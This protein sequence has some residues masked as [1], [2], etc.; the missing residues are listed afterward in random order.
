MKNVS[1]GP[2]ERTY[3]RWRIL[4]LLALAIVPFLNGISNDFTYDDKLIIRDNSRLENRAS[5]GLVFTTHYF[6]GSLATGQNYRPVVL[7]SYAVQR[8][9]HGN[10]APLFRVVNIA[11]HA[12]VCILLFLWIR[13]LGFGEGMSFATSLWFAAAAI[14]VE[15]VT[16]LVGRAEL[17]AALLVLSSALFWLWATREPGVAFGPY[18]LALVCFLISVFVKE[19]AVVL[20]GVILLGELFR[21]GRSSL[22]F[23]RV[24]SEMRPRA[25]WIA[26]FAFPL[27][28]LFGVRFFVLQGFL[29]SRHAG[30]FEVE[31]PLVTVPA[32]LRGMNGVWLLGRYA[33]TA[34]FP[35][36]LAADHSAYALRPLTWQDPGLLVVTAIG[37]LALA[38]SV[39][40]LR[41]TT[42]AFAFGLVFFA[43][44][45]FPASNIP[46]AVG[47]IFAERLAY[48]PSAG[49]F[50]AVLALFAPKEWAV[51]RHSSLRWRELLLG[52]VVLVNVVITVERNRVW[53]DDTALF[54]DM[55]KK[56]PE[57]SKARYNLA[58][59]L[60][61][62]KEYREARK[63]LAKA[64]EIFPR[65]YDAH[66]LLGRIELDAGNVEKSVASYRR[67]A[68]IF[69][70]NERVL[71]GL[72]S[73]LEASARIGEAEEMLR[74]SI[75]VLPESEGLSS[76][77]ARLLEKKGEWRRAFHE[78]RRAR[79]LGKGSAASRA[80]LARALER[81]GKSAE[82]MDEARWAAWKDPSLAEP[83]FVMAEIYEEEGKFLPACVE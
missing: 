62:R 29:L 18:S 6:G 26:G 83:R 15:A 63:H 73:A 39:L 10:R 32:F 67:A 25:W 1:A 38:C 4:C 60:F 57:S 23:S 79:I 69:P 74:A 47:T 14:H 9:V 52:A 54:T 8:W 72:S 19:S 11:M 31:N 40:V 51:P 34:L 76:A 28:V 68:A 77:R 50:L 36:D 24:I 22:S 5:V 44:C 64:I 48:L 78:W 27:T 20:P 21:D 81:L 59:D 75:R 49:L 43:G 37:V 70:A 30:V 71:L 55:A 35:F 58:Y 61:R 42:P 12:G 46:F 45:F 3:T 65:H 33:M 2:E 17:L 80:G 13:A 7:L 41:R 82:A 66:A 56:R 16:S 53:R